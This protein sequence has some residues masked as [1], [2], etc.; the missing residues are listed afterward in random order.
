MVYFTIRSIVNCGPMM[1]H[2][3]TIHKR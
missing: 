1:N 3:A 2:L